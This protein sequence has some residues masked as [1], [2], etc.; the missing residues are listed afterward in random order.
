M[1][2]T[3][4]VD[5]EAIKPITKASELPSNSVRARALLLEVDSPSDGACKSVNTQVLMVHSQPPY[6]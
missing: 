2:F 6:L 3:N 5:A 1:T 4:L